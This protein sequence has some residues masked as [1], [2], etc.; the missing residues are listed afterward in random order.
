MTGFKAD[1]MLMQ[2]PF[3]AAA[4]FLRASTVHWAH[5]A[6]SVSRGRAGAQAAG[7]FYGRY[8]SGAI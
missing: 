2:N 6:V 4:P 3:P 5:V 1:P 7:N 8:R